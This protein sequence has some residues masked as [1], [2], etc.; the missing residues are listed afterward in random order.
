MRAKT[1]G[2]EQR[3]AASKGR[4]RTT[5]SGRHLVVPCFCRGN[6]H[7]A[8]PA[9]RFKHG[10][11]SGGSQ[12]SPTFA[13]RKRMCALGSACQ[14]SKSNALGARGLFP[15]SGWDLPTVP[16]SLRRAGITALSA[17]KR[18]ILV[19]VAMAGAPPLESPREA[20][21]PARCPFYKAVF[22]PTRGGPIHRSTARRRGDIET[23][24]MQGGRVG[25]ASTSLLNQSAEGSVPVERSVHF[26][27]S[28]STPGAGTIAGMGNRRGSKRFPS[29]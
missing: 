28:A 9:P 18:F 16:G 8:L 7:G 19:A 2:V 13:P 5:V 20:I 11:A 4:S 15:L 12:I 1:L 24:A 26:I 14:L 21:S 6:G 10:W 23:S 17:G 29:K 25:P 27:A 3:L 22:D